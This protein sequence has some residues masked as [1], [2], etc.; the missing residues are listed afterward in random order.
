VLSGGE[1]SRLT[2]AR[3]L[4][5][6]GNFLLLDEPT[7]DLDLP[8]LRVL[9][10]ALINFEGCV[11]V[12]S[13]DRYFLNRVCTGIMA[14]EGDGKIHFSEGGYEYYVEKLKARQK[15]IDEAEIKIKKEDTREKPSVK[16]LTWKEK[17][18]L[19]TIEE[20]IM[21][22][23]SVVENIEA[24]FSSPEF[25]DKY[26]SQTNELNRELEEAKEKV[27]KLYERWEELEEIKA[28]N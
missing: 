13:H 7:N 21:N 16:K 24:I 20:E 18:E 2:L 25:Y 10:E 8:T 26:A 6:G 23:E 19:E 28:G 27:K 11:V 17:K 4:K 12:V 14:L 3:I 9:E 1:K 5:N 15:E 22:A